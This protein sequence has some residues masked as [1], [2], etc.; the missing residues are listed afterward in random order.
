MRDNPEANKF[1][2]EFSKVYRYIL[3]NQEKELVALRSEMDFIQPYIF[4]LQKRFPGGLEVSLDVPERY[5]DYYIIPAALQMLI[6]NA[7]KHNVVSRTKPLHIDVYVNGNNTLTIKN[8]LQPKQSEEPSTRIG[9]VN[10][11]KRYAMI[12]GQ[13]VRIN[14]RSDSFVVELPLLSLN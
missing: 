5:K 2:E 1:I 10:I 8:N 11:K 7:I 9:L 4:L 6:E 12:S 3:N 13:E 14:R